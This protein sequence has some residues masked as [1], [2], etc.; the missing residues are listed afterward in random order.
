MSPVN[1]SVN[2][3]RIKVAL[4]AACGLLILVHAF[5]FWQ[6]W[7]FRQTAMALRHELEQMAVKNAMLE[8]EVLKLRYGH[9]TH[10][11]RLNALA[12][13][14]YASLLRIETL[15]TPPL[16]VQALRHSL[17]DVI[18]QID[19][20]RR[21]NTV[22]HNSQRYLATLSEAA[23]K[24]TYP[25]LHADLYALQRQFLYLEQL[26][27]SEVQAGSPPPLWLESLRDASLSQPVL[28]PLLLHAQM[29]I[30]EQTS[31]DRLTRTISANVMGTHLVGL[32]RTLA[33]EVRRHQQRTDT[34]VGFLTAGMVA[35]LVMLFLL[36]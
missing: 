15:S 7:A 31:L 18:D 36:T 5:Q 1:S 12:A 35:L 34:Q 22:V 23:I 14:L 9:V 21:S 26:H 3:R 6:T 20:F 8:G 10:Y 28:Q 16:D 29:L 2:N 24:Q 32:E 30:R 27:P 11:D 17:Q 33:D 19:R 4:L 13:S 25:A